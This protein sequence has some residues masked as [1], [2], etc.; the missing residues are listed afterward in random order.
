MGMK[1]GKVVSGLSV[2]VCL[3]FS[4]IDTSTAAE[5]QER[6]DADKAFGLYNEVITGKRKFE[7]LT[8]PEKRQVQ[9]V[10]E[11]LVA[12]QVINGSEEGC[13]NA[14]DDAKS[15]ANGFEYDDRKFTNCAKSK[16]LDNNC[17]REFKRAKDAFEE[18]N[19]AVSN[20]NSKCD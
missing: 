10:Y 1:I 17:K 14:R 9:R 20:V 6:F 12:G 11:A 13:K 2:A 5:A 3:L 8:E 18:Y 15:A 16:D 19:S 7:S 4:A